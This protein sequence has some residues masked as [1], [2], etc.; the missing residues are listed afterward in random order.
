MFSRK[1]EWFQF[2]GICFSFILRFQMNLGM[3][4]FQS[5]FCKFKK[6]SPKIIPPQESWDLKTGG[7]EIPDPCYTH[8]NPS[9]FRRLQWFLEQSQRI[10][11]STEKK[12][13]KN[14]PPRDPRATSTGNSKSN[15]KS[16]AMTRKGRDSV[17]PLADPRGFQSKL[18]GGWVSTTWRAVVNNHDLESRVQM[19]LSFMAYR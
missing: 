6:K 19:A 5:I 8:P 9:T 10:W 17:E 16:K 13:A 4:P 18:L 7:L 14:P 3:N 15:G 12:T 1:K 2:F 11:I